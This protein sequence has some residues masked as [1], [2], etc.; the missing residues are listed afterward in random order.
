MFKGKNIWIV[1]LARKEIIQKFKRKK[2]KPTI[3]SCFKSFFNTY[4][5]KL[6]HKS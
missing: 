1:K 6:P 4:D 5:L 3:K 2:F